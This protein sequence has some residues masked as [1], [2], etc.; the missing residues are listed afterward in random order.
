MDILVKSGR[1]SKELAFGFHLGAVPPFL[2]LF[3]VFIFTVGGGGVH[4]QLFPEVK[5]SIPFIVCLW[6]I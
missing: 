5:I 1:F 3:H 6:A 4:K 2:L